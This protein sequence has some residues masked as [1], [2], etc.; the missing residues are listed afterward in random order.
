MLIAAFPVGKSR[1]APLGN[2]ESRQR[3]APIPQPIGACNIFRIALEWT[4][5]LPGNARGSLF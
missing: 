3:R 1:V 5:G 2:V 4:K